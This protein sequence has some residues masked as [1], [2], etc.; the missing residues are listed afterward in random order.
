MVPSSHSLPLPVSAFSAGR[1]RQNGECRGCAGLHPPAS[2]PRLRRAGLPPLPWVRAGRPGLRGGFPIPGWQ[3][4]ARGKGK[5]GSGAF[6]AGCGVCAAAVTA[7]L[8]LL[9]VNVPKT[10]RTYCKKCGKHQP[11]KVTQ[12][13]KG[14]DSLYAQGEHGLAPGRGPGELR[15]VRVSCALHGWCR[16][17]TFVWPGEDSLA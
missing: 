1:R 16:L 6:G 8:L 5:G 12:Y 10:R 2:A 3:R 4:R 9:Q 17:G 14:K 15:A 7:S 13:K 11:H